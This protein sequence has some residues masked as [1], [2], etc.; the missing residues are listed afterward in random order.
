MIGGLAAK[1]DTKGRVRRL[2]LTSSPKKDKRGRGRK[3][4]ERFLGDCKSQT[5]QEKRGEKSVLAN[6]SSIR[7]QLETLERGGDELI[8]KGQWGKLRPL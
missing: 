6:D 2:S 5:Y 4:L 1:R 7:P 8:Q 3:V